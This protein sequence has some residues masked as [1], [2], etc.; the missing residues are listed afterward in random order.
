MILSNSTITCL[1]EVKLLNLL[2]LYVVFFPVIST[3]S[4]VIIVGLANFPT[5]TIIV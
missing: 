5:A 4:S 1:L 2:K 3:F